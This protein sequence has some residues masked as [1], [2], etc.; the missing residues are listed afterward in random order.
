MEMD[1]DEAL[2]LAKKLPNDDARQNLAGEIRKSVGRGEVEFDERE[3][4]MRVADKIEA[5]CTTPDDAPAIA[6][7]ARA[8]PPNPPPR[9]ATSGA[10]A[11]ATS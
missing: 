7:T 3:E 10:R 8:S 5:M 6:R 1:F 4:Y 9:A 11:A 2:E